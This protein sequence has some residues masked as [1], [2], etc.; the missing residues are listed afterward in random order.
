M[1]VRSILAHAIVSGAVI[2]G[3]M[4]RRFVM[5]A[6]VIGAVIGYLLGFIR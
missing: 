4:V 2:P 1:V 6:L 3:H 5:Y